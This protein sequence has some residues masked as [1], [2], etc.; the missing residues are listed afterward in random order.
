M[1]RAPLNLNLSSSMIRNYTKDTRYV[2]RHDLTIYKKRNTLKIPVE[3][4]KEIHQEAFDSRIDS[5]IAKGKKVVFD[6]E[7]TR[8]PMFRKPQILVRKFDGTG[9]ASELVDLPPYLFQCTPRRDILHSVVVWQLARRRQGSHK[10]KDRYEVAYSKRKIYRQKG[11]GRA[12]HGSRGAPQFRGGGRAFAKRP[13]SYDY[14]LPLRVRRLGL[15]MALTRSYLLGQLVIVDDIRSK[16]EEIPKTRVMWRCL[17]GIEA[18]KPAVRPLV[19]DSTFD[20]N[21]EKSLFRMKFVQYTTI[22]GLN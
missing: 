16:F 1:I 9:D 11:T 15:R 18:S 10:T 12:R 7:S 13:K 5:T 21:V 20:S 19:V 14:P 22:D 17:Q 4:V 2:K 6:P 8:P 3:N